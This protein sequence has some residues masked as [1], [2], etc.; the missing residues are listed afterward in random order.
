MKIIVKYLWKIQ[1]WKDTRSGL[2][3]IR[4]NG[5]V[6]SDRSRGNHARDFYEY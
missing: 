3:R 4:F 6:C 1:L 2:D 5:R